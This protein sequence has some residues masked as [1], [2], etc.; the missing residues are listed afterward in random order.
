[1]HRT[2]SLALKEGRGCRRHIAAVLL[3]AQARQ[4]ELARYDDRRRVAASLD[5]R[6]LAV[7]PLQTP[8]ED[9]GQHQ[10]HILAHLVSYVRVAR[11]QA[12]RDAA[13]GDDEHR[14]WFDAASRTGDLPVLLRL[15][16]RLRVGPFRRGQRHHPDLVARVGLQRQEDAL[17][18]CELVASRVEHATQIEHAF[19]RWKV[20]GVRR[21]SVQ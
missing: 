11:L 17:E 1:M 8:P 15:Q 12:A 2:T 19:L 20:S 6:A 7:L 3:V 14:V 21:R 10:R 13:V 5:K 9:V 4:R 18:P 16:Q